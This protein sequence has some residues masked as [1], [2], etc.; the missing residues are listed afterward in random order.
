MVNKCFPVVELHTTELTPLENAIETM[1]N[2]NNEVKELIKKFAHDSS[3]PLDPLT[4]KLSGMAFLG[5]E[6]LQE[7]PQ[8]TEKL[9]DLRQLIVSQV[10]LLDAALQIHEKRVSK[11]ISDLHQ[12]MKKSF[13]KMRKHVEDK[14][15]K[16]TLPPDIDFV[17][18]SLRLQSQ[19]SVSSDTS[20][21]RLSHQY[22]GLSGSQSSLSRL[23]LGPSKGGSTLPRQKSSHHS[24]GNA[25]GSVPKQSKMEKG[26]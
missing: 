7:H 21:A 1:S 16:G 11:E 10:P 15:G 18:R 20:T 9:A 14:Y 5:D 24:L 23:S 8:D 6:Y 25:N 22:E 17:H 4:R 26:L 3:L 13:Q 19:L 12:H 2:A